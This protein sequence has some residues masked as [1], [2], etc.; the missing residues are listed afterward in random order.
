HRFM[1]CFSVEMLSLVREIPAAVGQIDCFDSEVACFGTP[2]Q[3]WLRS[4]FIVLPPS[5]LRQ[6]RS[7]TTVVDRSAI[8]SG[9]PAEPFKDDAPLS[10]TFRRYIAGWLTGDGTG[11]GVQWHSRFSLDASTLDLFQD[12]TIAIINEHMLTQRLRALGCKI[13]DATWLAQQVQSIDRH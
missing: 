6:L 2:W 9:N 7:V 12:K 8:F 1:A 4:S 10:P 13:V 5:Q 3:S 11:Q